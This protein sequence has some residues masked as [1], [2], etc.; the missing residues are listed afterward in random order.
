MCEQRRT[1]NTHILSGLR[2]TLYHISLQC[3]PLA[4]IYH[5]VKVKRRHASRNPFIPASTQRLQNHSVAT[6]KQSETTE[7]PPLPQTHTR[8]PSVSRQQEIWGQEGFCDHCRT[9]YHSLVLT[10][11]GWWQGGLV[12][13][14]RNTSNLKGV[15]SES[16]D[17]IW[18]KVRGSW[19][20]KTLIFFTA[21]DQAEDFWAQACQSDGPHQCFGAK[22]TELSVYGVDI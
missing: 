20:W 8:R 15:H 2:R 12:V 3:H 5:P 18:L 10:R 6:L 11:A 22:A 9:N 19:D 1:K 16:S 7:M 14:H 4:L 21:I 17:D 13:L